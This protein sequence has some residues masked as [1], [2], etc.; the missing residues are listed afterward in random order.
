MAIR[1]VYLWNVKEGHDPQFVLN[2]MRELNK[3]VPNAIRSTVG[4][5][6]GSHEGT[7]AESFQ[8]AT[9]LDV[10]NYEDVNDYL[11]HPELVELADKMDASIQNATSIEYPI[12]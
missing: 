10:Q 7:N 12:D 5:S 2:I 11:N 9:T 8:Y 6:I 3:H 1:H 4:T